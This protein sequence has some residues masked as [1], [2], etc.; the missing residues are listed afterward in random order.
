MAERTLVLV[1][2]LAG[3]DVT[4]KA[5]GTDYKFTGGKITLAGPDDFVNGMTQYM[6]RNFQALPEGP[7]AE[8][9]QKEI[10]GAREVHQDGDVSRGE[11][12]VQSGAGGEPSTQQAA[13]L[14][15]AGQAA[16]GAEGL[17]NAT[18]DGSRAIAEAVKAL[19][20][21]NDDLWTADGKPKMAALE[22]ALGRTD[23]T[24]A[25]VNAATD[26]FVRPAAA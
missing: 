4:L 8:A 22:A 15:G 26:N 10:D 18:G 20:P 5:G 2:S 25:M 12:H 11:A 19:D 24:R 13:D 23:V 16:T 3:K 1:G 21:A 17:G 7:A 6:A 9:L 14:S